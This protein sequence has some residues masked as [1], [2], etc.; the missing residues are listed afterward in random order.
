MRIPIALHASTVFRCCL[1]VL[2]VAAAAAQADDGDPDPAFAGTGLAIH[3]WPPA[4][5]LQAETTAGAVTVDGGVVA[6]G[7]LSYS[8]GQQHFAVTLLRWRADGTPD[9]G[10]GD[11]GVARLDLDAAPQIRETILAVFPQPSGKLLAVAGVQIPEAMAF[12][13]VLL[14][15]R[16]DGTPDTAFGAGGMWPIDVSQWDGEGDVQIRTAAIQPDGRILLAGIL[17]TDSGYHMLVG[18]ILPDGSLDTSFGEDGWRENGGSGSSNRGP[19]AIT[20]DDLGRILVAGRID[21][22]PDDKPL[23]LRL[24]AD[25]QYDTSFGP[26]ADGGLTLDGLDGSW[27]TRSIVSAKRIIAG[28]FVQR[29]IFLA[30]SANSPNRTAVAA[31]ADDGSPA[32]SF[33]DDGYV[34]LA[35][36]EGSRITALAMRR[37]WRL[38]A[39]G[40]IDPNGSGTGTD[41]FVARMDFGGALDPTFSGNGVERYPLDPEG[42]TYDSAAAL[43]LSGERPVIVGT[44]YDNSTPRWYGT[45]LRLRSDAIFADGLEP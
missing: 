42:L 40:F 43:L 37:D 17:V 39:A 44:A 5:T 4:D 19:E 41:L 12:R 24:T 29:R 11:N 7:Q 8:A 10:F 1:A 35:R 26:F 13:P 18:R 22:D 2:A 25:G 20:V 6:A 14:S 32:T 27:T 30:I 28:G 15:V 31:L 16:P 45:A 3:A 23:V 36:E 38:V 21:D 9:P 33:G 34:D